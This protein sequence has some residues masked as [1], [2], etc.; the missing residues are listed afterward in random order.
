LAFFVR[1]IHY[2]LKMTTENGSHWRAPVD[3]FQTAILYNSFPLQ[4]DFQCGHAVPLGRMVQRLQQKGAASCPHCAAPV[5][6][7]VDS[8]SKDGNYARVTFKY[9]KQA[10]RLSVHDPPPIW[11]RLVSTLLYRQQPT[12]QVRIAQVLGLD[13]SNGMK[14]LYKGKIIYPSKNCDEYKMSQ[15]LLDASNDSNDDSPKAPQHLLLV[16]GTPQV[17]QASSWSARTLLVQSLEWIIGMLWYVG[18]NAAS[19]LLLGRPRE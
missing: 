11:L 7:I 5:A 18:R 14:I 16:M 13:G 10:Y 8:C 12:A 1:K 15:L 17:Q 9:G 3:P 19:L 2:N 6:Y 4:K